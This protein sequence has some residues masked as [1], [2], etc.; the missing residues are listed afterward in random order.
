MDSRFP[1]ASAELLAA[2]Q[3]LLQLRAQAGK[4]PAAPPT[5]HRPP[6]T[7]HR[8]PLTGHRSL[9]TD[10]RSPITDHRPPITDHR[11]PIT[12][13]RLPPHLG[14]ESERVTAV[15][16]RAISQ[17]RVETA[18]DANTG[19]LTPPERTECPQ[20]G[21]EM[22]EPAAGG[23]V[24]LYPDIA[25]GML[26]QEM[27]APGRV[28]LLAHHLDREGRGW[29]RIDILIRYLTDK[30][31]SLRICGR[32]QLRNLLRQGEGIFWT[33]DKT[34]L[35]LRS[36]A[37]TAYALGV[38]R[39]AG[40]PVALPVA[41]LTE[42]IG[43]VRAHLYASFHSGRAK[44]TPQGV[45][46]MPIARDT[47]AGL[48][49]VGRVSQRTYERK[50]GVRPQANFAV[51]E[52][53]QAENR[54]NRAWAQGGALFE[55]KDYRGRQGK[56]GRTYLAWQLPNSYVGQHQQRPKGRQKRINRELKDLVMKGMPGN[57]GAAVGERPPEK[58]YYPNGKLAAQSYGRHPDRELYWRRQR[59]ENGRFTMWQQLGG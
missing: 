50:A 20:N 38:T 56:K 27:A 30:S 22:P 40:R 49:G 26:R 58:V 10:H 24:K 25:L 54:E 8:P 55:L 13:H 53:A 14:W 45:Q 18:G 34:R 23:A 32:R 42:G 28:W 4:R 39:L 35:W 52:A 16:R 7:A 48:S 1:A 46:A 19:W 12:D 37:K 43:V 5:G 9:I 11:P 2:N 57:V 59:T 17:K 29:L 41:V 36:A 44:E 33:R 31:S 51:G 21:P 3:R 47:L 15:I 6:A